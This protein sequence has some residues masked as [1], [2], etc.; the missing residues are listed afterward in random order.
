MKRKN[1]KFPSRYEDGVNKGKTY[2]EY[3]LK[4]NDKKI[5]KKMLNDIKN[6]KYWGVEDYDILVGPKIRKNID[7]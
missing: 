7:G 5:V 4:R 6:N 3:L 2:K 1:K